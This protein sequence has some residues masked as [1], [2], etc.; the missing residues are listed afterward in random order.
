MKLKKVSLLI[1]L[2]LSFLTITSCNKQE[3]VQKSFPE[4]I[5]EVKSY[6][7]SGKLETFF[8]S[9]AK[10][11]EVVVYYQNPNQYRVEL[12]NAGNNEPQIMIKNIDGTYVL[13]PAVNKIFKVNSS[14]PD[15]S[16]YPY[17]LQSLSKDIISDENIISTKK[18]NLETLELKAKLFDNATITKQKISFNMSKGL[19]TEVLVYD[20]ED[21]LISRFVYNNIE[22]NYKIDS[23]IFHVNE[24]MSVARLV[25]IEDPMLFDRIISYPTFFPD[26]TSLEQENTSGIGDD[27]RVIMKYSGDSPFTI[28]E[29][30]VS[31]TETTKIE[32]ITGSIYTMGGAMCIVSNNTIFF[33]DGGIEYLVASTTLSYTTMIQMGESLRTANSK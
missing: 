33:Y 26:G 22:L 15:N 25:Y 5:S 6:K 20:D 8:P 31:Q 28:V 4:I 10:E 30:L 13:L 3:D 14:W 21:T 18:D 16:S 24:S 12:T 32:Y 19:P 9:G 2:F 17:I 29:Q 1:L 23:N 7:L 11:C 27:R